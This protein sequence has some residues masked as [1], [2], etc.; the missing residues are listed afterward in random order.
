[1]RVETFQ[2]FPGPCKSISHAL[3]FSF[4]FLIFF[5]FFCFVTA[6]ILVMLIKTCFLFVLF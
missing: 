5:F 4:S 2:Q 3:D 6:L 1:M